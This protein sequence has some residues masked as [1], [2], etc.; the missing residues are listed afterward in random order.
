MDLGSFGR[1]AS[2]LNN[3]VKLEALFNCVNRHHDQ[4]SSYKGKHLTVGLLTVSEAYPIITMVGNI[5][6]C[7]VL[8]Q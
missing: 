8:E 5:M 6:A 2:V 7:T 1:A 3:G 4:G